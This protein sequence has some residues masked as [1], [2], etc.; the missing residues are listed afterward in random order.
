MLNRFS[1]VGE[2]GNVGNLPTDSQSVRRAPARLFAARPASRSDL[3]KTIRFRPAGTTRIS[4]VSNSLMQQGPWSW[5]TRFLKAA[6]SW[7]VI[8]LGLL[9]AVF[10][11]RQAE[12]FPVFDVA[13]PHSWPIVEIR[14]AF[15]I[16]ALFGSITAIRNRRQAGVLLL[17]ATPVIAAS[18][19]WLESAH[20][21]ASFPDIVEAFAWC[22][23]FF[24]VPAA[25]WLLT[26]WAKWPPLVSSRLIPGTRIPLRPVAC[27]LLFVIC[28]GLGVFA[29][30][31]TE[32]PRGNYVCRGARSDLVSTQRFPGQVVFTARVLLVGNAVNAY[33]QFSR[34]CIARVERRYWGLPWW[35]PPVVILRGF[36]EQ[37]ERREYFIDGSPSRGLF[38]HFLPI[39]EPCPC[40]HWLHLDQAAVVQ[41]VLEEGPP[42]SGARVIGLVFWGS[43]RDQPARGVK[44]LVTGPGGTISITTDRHGVYERS[45]LPPGHYSIR[46][47]AVDASRECDVKSGDNWGPSLLI[48]LA[49]PWYGRLPEI[50][51]VSPLP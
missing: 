6:V 14:A 22:S 43:W 3:G 40:G 5:L 25:F 10:G 42:K 29:A 11:I 2:F 30:L 44:V 12:E 27:S 26:A 13:V 48:P 9:L 24:A 41:R 49:L 31:N 34:W 1:D 46:P 19:A 16:I 37:G 17:V 28:L 15:A 45:G 51:Y 36:F 32:M 20:S 38:T 47:E 8:V 23:L 21:Y 7:F 18:A 35:A 39:V 33:N 50:E 4:S